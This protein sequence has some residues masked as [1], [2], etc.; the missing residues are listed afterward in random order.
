MQIIT[1]KQPRNINDIM[2]AILSINER[3]NLKCECIYH[4]IFD[5]CNEKMKY[6]IKFKF[7]IHFLRDFAH[8]TI[9]QFLN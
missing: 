4:V 7:I 9:F 3:M 1:N 2:V 5:K 8:G 6:Q